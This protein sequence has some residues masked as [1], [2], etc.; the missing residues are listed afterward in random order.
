MKTMKSRGIL[1]CSIEFAGSNKQKH[2]ICNLIWDGFSMI[3]PCDCEPM[4][5]TF[6]HSRAE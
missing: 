6:D 5:G 4:V 2:S 3:F 1:Q